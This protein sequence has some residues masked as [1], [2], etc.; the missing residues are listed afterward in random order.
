MSLVYKSFSGAIWSLIDIMFNKAIFFIATLILARIIGPTE[1]GLLGLIMIFVAIGNTFIDS[2]FSVSLVR[3]IKPDNSDYSTVFYISV[4]LSIM[5][6]LFTFI[7]APFVA[8][9]YNQQ[10]LKSLIRLFCLSFIVN[11]FRII[12]QVLLVKEMNFKKITILNIPGNVIGLFLGVWMATNGYKI[13]SIVGLHL[14]TQIVTSFMFWIF[15]SWRPALSFSISKMRYHLNFGYKLMLSAQLNTIFDNIYNVLI[16]KYYSIQTLGYYERAYSLNNYPVSVIAGIIN[17]VSLP[18]FSNIY[19]DRHRMLSVYRKILVLSFYISTPL[20]MAAIVL[21][22]P[23]FILILGELWLPAVPF[24][25][26]LCISS[27]L[28]PIHALNINILSVHGRSDLFLK[29]EVIK[30]FMVLLLVFI[31]IG[32]GIYGLVWSSVIASVVALFINT[33][34]SGSIIMYFVRDQLNDILPTFFQSVL[35]T[36]IMFL[37][38]NLLCTSSIYMQVFIPAIVGLIV[39]ITVSLIAKNESLHIILSLMKN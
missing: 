10:I 21:A 17:K 38:F 37:T 16:G 14:S 23:M 27:I 9:F 24:F 28:Y 33:Y 7:L 8:D 3:T 6:Y 22:E 25:Q 20:M 34:Y 12:P 29:L 18:L 39:Y 4:F 36:I 26:I 19:E 11:A 15:N 2:G 5:A 32:F 1:F 13:W 30:K 31:S 35:T